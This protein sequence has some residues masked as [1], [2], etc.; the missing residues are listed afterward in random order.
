M[1]SIIFSLPVICLMLAGC[2]SPE[3]Q[4]P[5]TTPESALPDNTGDTMD[6]T[7]DT[8]AMPGEYDPSGSTPETQY[9]E[10]EII[11]TEG[12]E[13]DG[14]ITLTSSNGTVSIEGQITGLTPGEHGFHVHANGDC[15]APDAATAG[16][17]F[18]PHGD[19]HGAPTD[20]PG[21]HHI[22]DLGNITADASGV[23]RISMA[24]TTLRLNGSE[25]V[26]GKAFIVHADPDDLESQPS[27][28][29]GA[30]VGCGVIHEAEQVQDT[31]I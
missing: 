9:A 27:G 29:A 8:S 5:A 30:R 15:S 26:I 1:K 21:E 10:A 2:D 6:D 3:P 11:P 25:S 13:T 20:P 12:Q 18:A 16:G 23:A 22:G 31:A 24:D 19:P 14:L 7:D 4:A 17:H 28:N